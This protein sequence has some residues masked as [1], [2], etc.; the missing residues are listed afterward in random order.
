MKLFILLQAAWHILNP[1]F[2]QKTFIAA[3]DG[4]F[5]ITTSVGASLTLASESDTLTVERLQNQCL[6]V[7]AG[8]VI[9]VT[10]AGKGANRFKPVFLPSVG[11]SV[12][13]TTFVIIADQIAVFCNQC[14]LEWSDNGLDW[15]K[16]N[17]VNGEYTE[18]IYYQP[19]MFSFYRLHKDGKYSQVLRTERGQ[20]KPETAFVQYGRH[21]IY[22]YSGRKVIYNR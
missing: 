2:N 13:Y 20:N 15:I 16:I 3:S 9:T 1:A 21:K 19:G 17:E 10:L 5:C 11:T 22:L 4:D 12:W 7:E 14:D 6:R 8:E 18:P